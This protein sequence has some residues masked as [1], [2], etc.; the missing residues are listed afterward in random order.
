VAADS[1]DG[2]VSVRSVSGRV[3]VGSLREGT[4]SVQSVSGGIDLGIAA[5]TSIDIDAASASGQLS[6]E[7]ALGQAPGAESGPT[8]VIRGNTVS[9]DFRVFRAA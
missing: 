1:V 7:I 8:V 5:G 6:S 4:T 3:H 9:G 2:S